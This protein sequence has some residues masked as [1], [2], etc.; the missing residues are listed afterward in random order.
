MKINKTKHSAGFS[1]I[2]VL[3][4][5]TILAI[6]FGVIFEIF[7]GGLRRV[8]DGSQGFKAMLQ[9]ETLMNDLGHNLPIREGAQQG[10]TDLG[11]KW[12]I[13][14]KPYEPDM[15]DVDVESPLGE[16]YDIS[17]TV[18]W[19][20]GLRERQVTIHSLRYQMGEP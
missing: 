11:Y 3:V 12:Q 17:I 1:L 10:T 5:L 6:S 16:L 14:I 13:D 18:R 4:A 20:S 7:S 9:A 19:Q 15:G 8:N 2:E